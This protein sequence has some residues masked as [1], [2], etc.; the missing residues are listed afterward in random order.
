MKKLLLYVVKKMKT[1]QTM[2]S[3]RRRVFME[4]NRGCLANI[5]INISEVKIHLL[6]FVC[7][8]EQ[9]QFDN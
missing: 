9:N 6:S 3:V 7:K 8:N 4:G 2:M 1:G 5:V